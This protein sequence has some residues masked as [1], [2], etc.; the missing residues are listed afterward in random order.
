MRLT[1]RGLGLLVAGASLALLATSLQSPAAARLAALVLAI[2]AVSALWALWSRGVSRRVGVVRT[3]TPPQLAVGQ[4]ATVR[5]RLTVR[6]L[7][8]W[9][10]IRERVPAPLRR[11][12]GGSAGYVISPDRR[13]VFLLGPASVHRSDPMNL[14]RWRVT[15]AGTQEL[16]VW[17]RTEDVPSIMRAATRD[18]TMARPR[19]RPQR[20]LEDLTV[21][22]YRPG[23]DLHRVHWKSSARQGELMVRHDEPAT[24]HRVDVL[25]DLGSPQES[26]PESDTEFA[27]SACAS[28]TTS[29]VRDRY[30]VRILTHHLEAGEV[31]ND[32]VVTSSVPE[33]LDVFARARSAQPPAQA[34]VRLEHV[35]RI[36]RSGA[37]VVVAVL[38]EPSAA[39]LEDLA[40]LARR[41]RCIA[42]VVGAA[43]V[44]L[45][46][47]EQAGWRTS[48]ARG[49]ES[50]SATW[51]SALRDRVG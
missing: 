16:A 40:P 29:L 2:P 45:T 10:V 31:W 6:A 18:A 14:V 41:R 26:D 46:V 7:A 30:T 22:E 11:S 33:V 25:L 39:L 44:D 21:R 51:A 48:T 24:T 32:Q 49:H 36:E 50:I 35:H 4:S 20:N 42:L 47:L 1:T 12:G 3:I 34:W 17:P 15:S 23:D 27:V 38:R 19:G 43:G 28:L 8:P 13:G 37:G 9:T 5:L